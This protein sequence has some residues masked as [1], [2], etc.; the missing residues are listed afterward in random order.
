MG[1]LL[2]FYLFLEDKQVADHW[3]RHPFAVQ[4]PTHRGVQAN[5][6]GVD[7]LEGNFRSFLDNNRGPRLVS[8]AVLILYLWCVYCIYTVCI[9]TKLVLQFFTQHDVLEEAHLQTRALPHWS[10]VQ[11]KASSCTSVLNYP[12]LSSARRNL[13]FSGTKKLLFLY[14]SSSLWMSSCFCAWNK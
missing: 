8:V 13:P 5:V 4:R 2:Q 6:T 1:S 9:P 11:R 14:I 3:S 7:L 12:I 10:S